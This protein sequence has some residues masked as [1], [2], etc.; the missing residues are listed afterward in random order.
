[1]VINDGIYEHTWLVVYLPTP[2][3]NDGVNVRLGWLNSQLNGNIKIRFQ[4]TNQIQYQQHATQNSTDLEPFGTIIKPF[5]I[6]A[7]IIFVSVFGSSP[8]HGHHM[9]S[10]GA[11]ARFGP[12]SHS[13][14]PNLSSKNCWRRGS[15]APRFRGSEAWTKPWRTWTPRVRRVKWKWDLGFP[16]VAKGAKKA[17]NQAWP[18]GK[19]CPNF[20][21]FHFQHPFILYFPMIFWVSHS[22]HRFSPWAFLFI[23]DPTCHR[24]NHPWRRCP[25]SPFPLQV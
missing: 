17:S 8:K 21:H 2:L 20:S 18:A 3:K 14:S 15:E 5:F 19:I 16:G 10:P 22:N 9:A 13:M 12:L 25:G 4:T 11:P 1:M 6:C 23:P 7:C 24:T